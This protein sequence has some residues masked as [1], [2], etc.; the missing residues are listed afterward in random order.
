MAYLEGP[1]LGEELRDQ[2]YVACAPPGLQ[3]EVLEV[4]EPPAQHHQVLQGQVDTQCQPYH[5]LWHT[6]CIHP[7]TM[8]AVDTEVGQRVQGEEPGPEVTSRPGYR[9][10]VE[11]GEMLQAGKR[12]QRLLRDL[13]VVV[14]QLQTG[15][16]EGLVS[17][18]EEPQEHSV[19]SPVLKW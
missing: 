3:V 5:R 9:V 13:R 8:A 7:Q 12:R 1:E 19:I 4:G 6:V 15:Q 2:G 16:G 11:D 17:W 10:Q 14:Q 18:E